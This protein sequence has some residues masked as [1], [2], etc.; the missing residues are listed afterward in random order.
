MIE[1]FCFNDDAMPVF[2][3]RGTGQVF[4]DGAVYFRS[5]DYAFSAIQTRF[6]KTAAQAHGASFTESGEVEV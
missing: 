6:I 2:V 5:R 1:T 3:E 4:D